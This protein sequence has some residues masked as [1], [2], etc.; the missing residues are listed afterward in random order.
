MDVVASPGRILT[1]NVATVC[2]LLFCLFF[3]APVFAQTTLR[4][5]VYENTPKIFLDDAGQVSGIFG[6]LVTEIAE[7][8]NWLI[9]SVA[10]QWN[11]CL[12]MLESG[13]IDLMPDV[14]YTSSRAQLFD[15]HQNAVL[16]SWSQLYERDGLGLSS[17][18]DLNGRSV[19]VLEGSVQQIYLMEMAENF[20]LVIEWVW[21][22]SLEAAFAAVISGQADAAVANQ[23]YGDM[24]A[25]QHELARTPIMFQPTRLHFAVPTGRHAELLAVIDRYITSWQADEQ[26]PYFR[27]L[28]RWSI[29]PDAQGIPVVAWW[30]I[31]ALSF[32]LILLALF[33]VLLRIKVAEKTRSLVASESRLNTI[34]NSVDA[35]IYIKDY[36]LRYQ[37]ANRKVCDLFGVTPDEIVGKTDADFFSQ[38]TCA[39]LE[40]N[41]M[42][43]VR[44]GERVANEEASTL[45]RNQKTY[46]FLSVKLPLRNPDGSIYALC[47]ISTDISEH[48]QIR[49]QLHQLAF[50]DSLTGL[51]NRRL[52][53]DRLD[54]AL[55][56]RNQTGYEGALLFLDVDDFKVVNDTLGHDT[57]DYLLQLL[58][59]RL[60]RGLLSTDTAGRLGA[61]EFV[62]IIEDLAL[63]A[64]DSLVR[65][66]DMAEILRQ[67]LS[68]PFDLNG[69]DY[70]CAVSIGIA[71][72]SDADNGDV[73]ALLKAADLALDAAK[74]GGS[75]S[76][77]FFNPEMQVEVT[78]RTRIEAALRKALLGDNLSLHLQPQVD[79]AGN[80]ISMEALLRWHDPEMGQVAPSDF[81]PVA[82]TCGLIVPVGKWVLDRACRMLA[83]W[84]SD[85]VMSALT[86]AVNISPRQF[87]H[88]DFVDHIL[89][90]LKNNGVDGRRLELEVTEGLLIEDV[91]VTVAKMDRLREHGIR[92]S[93]DDFGTGYASL[94]YLKRLP[95]SQLKIDQSFVRDLLLDPND[96]AIV[97]TILALGKSLD[98]RVLAEGVETRALADR[99]R[100]M[101]CEYF[102]GYLFSRPQAEAYWREHPPV[103]LTGHELPQDA[104]PK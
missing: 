93:L 39:L 89:N 76:V 8:E 5:G 101:G 95:L 85:S 47:G 104:S 48:K 90:S 12:R 44:H 97:R 79:S 68:L 99:L 15:F 33:S 46:D 83:E 43:V 49:D 53:L 65:V 35:Y 50:F 81:I 67:Q 72:F 58:A 94:G 88:A 25:F 73:E 9:E 62:L 63:D 20:D 26:S 54:H 7:R 10:C 1:D 103:Q 78:R 84:Q 91:E 57:G 11:D 102:Q 19:A 45:V 6:E 77:C 64:D 74:T 31:G 29:N 38:Q 36:R 16:L 4:L 87:H 70:V 17:L 32:A 92:F 69:T 23:F 37:Y 61:D 86:L 59:R 55:A 80:V 3:S 51:P 27:I 71:M 30:L 22:D 18:L 42:R 66:R 52:V 100:E 28:R 56:N 96:E 34:L 24:M 40:Q 13:E 2:L 98:L 21:V 75:S 82:E 41:D 60:E 14:A